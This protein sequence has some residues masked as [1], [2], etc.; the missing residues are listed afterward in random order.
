MQLMPLNTMGT[1]LIKSS[2]PEKMTALAR[3]EQDIANQ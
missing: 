2:T 3:K 1:V